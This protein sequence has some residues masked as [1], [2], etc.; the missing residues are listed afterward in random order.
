MIDQQYWQ[1]DKDYALILL[2]LRDN[3][4]NWHIASCCIYIHITIDEIRFN[5]GARKNQALRRVLTSP[6]VC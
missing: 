6:L 5:I 1:P 3:N 2:L 4:Y